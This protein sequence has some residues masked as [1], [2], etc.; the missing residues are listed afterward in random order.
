MVGWCV[1]AVFTLYCIVVLL[2]AG[3]VWFV[4]E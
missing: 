1:F 2:I 3:T 4:S